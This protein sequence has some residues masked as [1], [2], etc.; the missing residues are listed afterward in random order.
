MAAKESFKLLMALSANFN[1]KIAS[2]NSHTAFLQSKVLD[3]EVYVEPPSDIK[4]QGIVWKLYQPLYGLD[5]ASWK[6]WLRV[7]DVFLNKLKLKTVEGDEA[8]YFQN[9]DGDFH[10]AVLTHVDDFEVTG[11]TY[12]V[13]KVIFC[14]RK[15]AYNIKVEEDTFGYTG[16][17][18]NMIADGN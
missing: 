1:F 10:G 9:L 13:D 18:V 16:L 15:R 4:K 5:D 11:T 14:G 12:F 6:F 2:V 17:N 3:R 7:R 8:F